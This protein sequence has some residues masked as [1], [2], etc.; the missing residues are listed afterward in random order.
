VTALLRGTVKKAVKAGAALKG[1]NEKDRGGHSGAKGTEEGTF[2]AS[3]EDKL[4]LSDIVFLRGWVRVDIPRYYNPVTSL[5]QVGLSLH[6]R[7]SDRLH[8]CHH[9]WLS[10]N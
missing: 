5:L 2:R 6:S 1:A 3:F 10:S 4:L 9:S 8:G 7:V